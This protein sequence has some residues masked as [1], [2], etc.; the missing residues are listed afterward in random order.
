MTDS[1]NMTSGLFNPI[2]S[3]AT[4]GWCNFR[5]V[6]HWNTEIQ[7]GAIRWGSPL[8]D[9]NSDSPYVWKTLMDCSGHAHTCRNSPT[10]HPALTLPA[11]Q[12]WLTMSWPGA[13][14]A[15]SCIRGVP[16]AWF[17]ASSVQRFC[18]WSGCRTWRHRA[19]PGEGQTG[20]LGKCLDREGGQRLGQAS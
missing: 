2:L 13:K 12:H 7:V 14:S 8:H 18:Q 17:R 11:P 5:Q 1:W 16:Q 10:P 15:T 6:N 19:A 9:C 20:H 4:F 3:S